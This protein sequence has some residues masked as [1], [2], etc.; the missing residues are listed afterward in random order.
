MA[1]V[2]DVRTK[3]SGL[4]GAAGALTLGR[5]RV[6]A[7]GAAV[8]CYHDIGTDPE[9]TTEYYVAP[10]LLRR[11]LD[12]IRGWGY[13][14]VPV[15]EIVDR[16]E[17]GRDLDGLCA[18]TFDDALVGVG[19][20]A[21]P[22]LADAAVPATVFAVTDVLGIA[23]PFWPGA[24]RTMTPE[25]LGELTA[26]GLVTLASHTA[27][28]ASL[29]DVDAGTRAAELTRSRDWLTGVGGITD[30]LAYPFGHVDDASA[31]AVDAAGYRAAFT[32]TFG[33]VVASTDRFAIPRFCIGPDHDKLRLARQLARPATV[34]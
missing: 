1:R 32:F 12:W 13:T 26:S 16:L 29:P 4:P 3:L 9:N 17:A 22:I 28:H 24:A 2:T 5:L 23:P 30:L 8:L 34:W 7:K 14:F 10:D 15:A 27:T 20:L 6:Q 18:V 21:A 11:H 25:E 31:R 33:R 19:E